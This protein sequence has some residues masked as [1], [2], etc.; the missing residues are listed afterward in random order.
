MCVCL[1]VCLFLRQGLALSPRLE[2]SGMISVHCNLCLLF[3]SNF[4]ASASRVAGITDM[5][6]HAWLILYF[7]RDG[8]SPCW[9]GWSQTPD[10]R[11]STRLSLPGCWDRRHEPA[12]TTQFINQKGTDRPGTAAHAC[13]PRTLDCQAARIA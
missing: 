9:S 5:Y 12:H 6:H 11:L 8:V 10:L 3:S 13:D 2:C 4:S 7:S 1:F